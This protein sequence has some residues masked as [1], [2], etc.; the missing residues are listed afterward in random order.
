MALV[1]RFKQDAEQPGC[2]GGLDERAFPGNAGGQGGGLLTRACPVQRA[3]QDSD[4]FR[5]RERCVAS[6]I[7]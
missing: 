2:R 6:G 5:G 7:A 3:E 1:T 4:G